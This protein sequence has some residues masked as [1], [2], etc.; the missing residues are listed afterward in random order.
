MCHYFKYS[1]AENEIIAKK[2]YEIKSYY[3]TCSFVYFVIQIEF[4]NLNLIK[5]LKEV[6]GK[7]IN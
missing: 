3:L 1:N 6:C 2:N 7:S 4:P 5:L